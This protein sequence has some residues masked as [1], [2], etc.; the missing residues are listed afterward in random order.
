MFSGIICSEGTQLH[1]IPFFGKVPLGNNQRLTKIAIVRE[2]LFH[3]LTCEI[4]HYAP[5]FAFVHLST[6]CIKALSQKQPLTFFLL[7]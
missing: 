4:G 6:F 1:S 5:R 2:L 3:V 7:L